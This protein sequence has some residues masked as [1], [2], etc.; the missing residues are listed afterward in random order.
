MNQES[1]AF[2]EVEAGECQ[3]IWFL[4]W[5]KPRLKNDSVLLGLNKT[6]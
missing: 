5:L 1:P 4:P 6:S 3:K 2:N